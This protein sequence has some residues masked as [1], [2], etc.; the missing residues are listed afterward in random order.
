MR[1]FMGPPWIACCFGEEMLEKK[2]G[3]EGLA[4][5]GEE[6][7]TDVVYAVGGLEPHLIAPFFWFA[8]G[9]LGGVV[10]D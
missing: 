4:G 3:C 1:P 10:V 8:V 6:V 2:V 9:G 5:K 7:C